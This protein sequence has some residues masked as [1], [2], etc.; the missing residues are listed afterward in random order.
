MASFL[1]ATTLQSRSPISAASPKFAE[2]VA[3]GRC[4]VAGMGAKVAETTRNQRRFCKRAAQTKERRFAVTDA[5]QR[6]GFQ[7]RSNGRLSN[8]RSLKVASRD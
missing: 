7:M 2:L 5:K 1:V 6:P 8:R 3:R 4:E